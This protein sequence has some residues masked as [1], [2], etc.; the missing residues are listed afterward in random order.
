MRYKSAIAALI[1]SAASSLFI[2]PPRVTAEPSTT[3]ST[4]FETL[5]DLFDRTFFSNDKRAYENSSIVRQFNN[6]FGP[7]PENEMNKDAKALHRLYVEVMNQQVSS[8]PILRTP[9]LPNP[10]NTSLFQLPSF[11]VNRPVVGGEFNYQELPP[12]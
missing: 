12:R 6:L 11:N 9:D 10:Y 2:F 1:L 7:F 8:D 5:N 3:R 4:R